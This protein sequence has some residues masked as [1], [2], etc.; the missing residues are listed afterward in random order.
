VGK[1]WYSFSAKRRSWQSST[2]DRQPLGL[3]DAVHLSV[4]VEPSKLDKLHRLLAVVPGVELHK[5][6]RH[7][8]S[9]RW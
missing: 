6:P 3:G 5:T 9:K 2:V 4:L 1:V 8:P 7:I